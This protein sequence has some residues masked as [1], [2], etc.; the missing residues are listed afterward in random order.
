MIN[1]P[2]HKVWNNYRHFSS[3]PTALTACRDSFKGII[4]RYFFS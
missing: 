3:L 1:L 2:N 4:A